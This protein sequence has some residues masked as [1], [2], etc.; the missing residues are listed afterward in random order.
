[1]VKLKEPLELWLQVTIEP[2]GKAQT[3]RIFTRKREIH[4]CTQGLR[5][6]L[7]MDTGHEWRNG[8]HLFISSCLI[9][10]FLQK[11][12]Q[13]IKHTCYLAAFSRPS[14]SQRWGTRQKREILVLFQALLLTLIDTVE[15][16]LVHI[17]F[18]WRGPQK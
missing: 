8:G 7:E 13:F 15:Q 5:W 10:S 14:L 6:N 4:C 9:S 18:L 17:H 12:K 16:V 3:E 2:K 11:E 1:M